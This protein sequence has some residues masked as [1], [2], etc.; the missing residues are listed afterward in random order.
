VSCGRE[1]I[2]AIVVGF[3]SDCA[4]CIKVEFIEELLHACSPVGCIRNEDL[5]TI[6][7][8]IGVVAPYVNT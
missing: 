1:G 6:I 8:Y 4:L 3:Q 7:H 5:R 2:V